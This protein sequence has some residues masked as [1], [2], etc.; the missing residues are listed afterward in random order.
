[1]LSASATI[2]AAACLAASISAFNLATS[3][4]YASLD[5]SVFPAKSASP[6][7][8]KSV[9]ALPNAVFCSGVTLSTN[10]AL[11]ASNAAFFAFTSANAFATSSVVEFISEITASAAVTACSAA[12]LAA[13]YLSDVPF[14]L[15]SVTFGTSAAVFSSF[16]A[17]SNSSVF[18]LSFNKAAALSNSALILSTSI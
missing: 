11:A 4:L 12:V 8:A 13:S 16:L 10:A 3:A 18:P 5:S 6:N 17:F 1:M 7:T 2:A 14:V 15:P 9:S